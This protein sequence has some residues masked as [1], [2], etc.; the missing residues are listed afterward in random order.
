[1]NVT[2]IVQLLPT[3]SVAGLIGQV[4]V[5]AKSLALTPVMAMLVIVSAPGP[6]L[7]SVALC[8]L[9]VVFVV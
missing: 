3:A 5:R 8:A 6:L 9:L 7:V 2:L 4:V 1:V